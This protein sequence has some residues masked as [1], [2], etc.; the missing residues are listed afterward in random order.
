MYKECWSNFH[1][2]A[3]RTDPNYQ[4][5]TN[6]PK[7][8]I[9]LNS[10]CEVACLMQGQDVAIIFLNISNDFFHLTHLPFSLPRRPPDWTS[11]F[12]LGYGVLI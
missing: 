11:P 9:N 1:N 5:D 6:L 8:R 2:S 12:S 10:R 4:I 7:F 3:N